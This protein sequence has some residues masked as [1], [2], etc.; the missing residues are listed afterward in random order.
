MSKELVWKEPHSG[1]FEAETEHFDYVVNDDGHYT[2]HLG[3][4]KH[5]T[6][7]LSDGRCVRDMKKDCQAHHNAILAAI[8]DSKPRW[9]PVKESLPD[10]EDYYEIA[11][12]GFRR[13][14]RIV[15]YFPNAKKF[16]LPNGEQAYP[17]HW[18]KTSALSPSPEKEQVI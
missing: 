2:I 3:K 6:V 11:E 5:R 18:K 15:A 8:E 1:L 9:I 16:L 7:I 13:V 4:A 12:E 14:P 10:E 17:T